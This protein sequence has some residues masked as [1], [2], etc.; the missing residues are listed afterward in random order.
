[1]MIRCWGFHQRS[2]FSGV[3]P[4]NGV[5]PSVNSARSLLTFWPATA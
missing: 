4:S 5:S 2:S 3:T 1:M